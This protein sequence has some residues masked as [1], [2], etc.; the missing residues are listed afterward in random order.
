MK[1]PV[2][3]NLLILLILAISLSSCK[4]DNTDS[5]PIF[6]PPKFTFGKKGN[7]IVSKTVFKIGLTTEIDTLKQKLINIETNNT[8]LISEVR[9]VKN[10]SITTYWL[11][12]ENEFGYSDIT[13]TDNGI[14]CKA[15]AKVNEKYISIY[16]GNTMTSQVVALKQNVTV[17]LGNFECYKVKMISTADPETT[18]YYYINQKYGIIKMEFTGTIFTTPFTYTQELISKNFI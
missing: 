5:D 3:I 14:I 15:D 17:P 8:W 2:K 12:T 1:N 4:K 10:D 13:G 6:A 9:S 18:Y 16:G 11:I 7:E